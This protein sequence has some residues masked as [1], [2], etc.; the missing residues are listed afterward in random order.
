MKSGE[1]AHILIEYPIG[2]KGFGWVGVKFTKLLSQ[3]VY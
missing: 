3:F 1:Q 2:K